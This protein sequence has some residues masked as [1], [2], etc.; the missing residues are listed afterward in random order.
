MQSILTGESKVVLT[1]GADSMSQAPYAVRNVRFGVPLGSNIAFE[2]TL[3]TGLIDTHC[4]LPMG[5]TAEKLGAMF[6]VTRQEVDEFSLRSQ[7]LWKKGK[8]AELNVLNIMKFY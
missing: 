7:V 2:D 8:C 1:G 6:K 4:K 5:L 3:W